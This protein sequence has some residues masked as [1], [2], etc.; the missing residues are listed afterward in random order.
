MKTIYFYDKQT[1]K[2]AGMDIIEDTAELPENATTAQPRSELLD[3][4]WNG[5]DW[6]GV[7]QE[8]YNQNHPSQPPEGWEDKPDELEILKKRQ[9]ATEEALQELILGTMNIE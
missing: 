2:Y 6:Q 4:Y 3:P 1:K 8:E 9:E 5:E 7:T